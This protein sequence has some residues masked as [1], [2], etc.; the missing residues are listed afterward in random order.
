MRCGLFELQTH[1]DLGT[2]I[3]LKTA[4]REIRRRMRRDARGELLLWKSD[5]NAVL[6]VQVANAKLAVDL[7][8]KCVKVGK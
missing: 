4:G 7:F 6:T 3:K 1:S 8:N 5:V 2:Q